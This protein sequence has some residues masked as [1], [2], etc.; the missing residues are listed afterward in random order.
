M[1]SAEAT[2]EQKGFYA[3]D[4]LNLKNKEKGWAIAGGTSV[5]Q[6]AWF[7]LAKPVELKSKD[8]VE[9]TLSFESKHKKHILKDFKVKAGSGSLTT[10]D[11]LVSELINKNQTDLAKEEKAKVVEFL[12]KKSAGAKIVARHAELSKKIKNFKPATT[13]IMQDLPK[14][15]RRVTRIFNRGSWEDLGDVVTEGVPEIFNE[16]KDEWPRNR[17]GMAKWMTHP[18]H[19]LLSRVA[20]NRFWEQIFGVGIVESLEDF[21]SQGIIPTHPKLLDDISYRFIHEHKWS[22][23]SLLKE[24]VT[25]ATYMQSSNATT[26][27]ITEDKFNSYLSRGPRFRLSSEQIRD[28]ALAVSGLLNQKMFGPSVMPHQPGGVWMGVYNGSKWITSKNGDQY[29]RGL[30]TYWKRTSPYPSMEAF[31]SPSREI[32]KTRRLRTNTPLQALVTLND[33]VIWSVPKSSAY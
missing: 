12:M 17:L 9:I 19:P 3:K 16:F 26:E 30:Y 25:S 27:K 24:F 5:E 14:D 33:P 31:D 21:G 29:R 18:D 13:P 32:C 11:L 10:E 1:G 6:T 20:V 7:K 4:S 23:K 15:K 22:V 2:Y 28:Q 8:K